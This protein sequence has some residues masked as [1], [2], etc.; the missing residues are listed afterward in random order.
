M[1]TNN[2]G[3]PQPFVSAATSD[4]QPT[5]NRYSVTTIL[6][7]TCEAVLWRRHG[8]E[9]DTD[10]S[11]MVWLIFGS[12]VHQILE[13]A[14][15]SDSQIKEN[16]IVVEV[17]NGYEMSGI[18]DLYDDST[19][20]VTDYKTCSVWKITYG[21]FEDW[22]KQTLL[23]CWML[24]QIGFDARHG[25]IVALIKDHSKRKARFEKGYPK[26]PTFRI[27]WDFTE[28]DM[29]NAQKYVADWFREI[30]RQEALDDDELVTCTEEQ[31]WRK[32]DKWAVMK[33][34]QK[35]AVRLYDNEEEAQ[36]RCDLENRSARN[37]SEVEKHYV[38]FRE[39]ED[40]KCEGYCEVREWCP[41]WK[42]K[43]KKEF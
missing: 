3:L 10:V 9:V 38:E 29:A 13:N 15:E 18:F 41:Y 1:L 39:G 33:I 35:R 19:G 34:G 12:A 23:Y 37:R 7:S 30:A 8:D 28:R 20:T 22:R 26:H 6:G 5:E 31:R 2:L 17:G 11:D 24:R 14:E 27:G 43:P 42:A 21:E 25:E 16:K 40:S 32:P 4:H 36:R